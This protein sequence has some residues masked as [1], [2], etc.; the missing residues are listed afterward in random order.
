M[1]LGLVASLT[2]LSSA[3]VL[4]VM[5]PALAQAA[6][7]PGAPWLAN[8]GCWLWDEMMERFTV[9]LGPYRFEPWVLDAGGAPGA[10]KFAGGVGSR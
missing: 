3:P 5:R 2:G 1:A 9:P 10:G 8:G 4:A 7:Q 6:E